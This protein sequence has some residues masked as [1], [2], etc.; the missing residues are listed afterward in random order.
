[1]QHQV[2]PMSLRMAG[3][4]LSAMSRPFPGLT[5]KLFY[6]LYCTPPALKLRAA[7]EQLRQQASMSSLQ[8]SSYP[9]DYT[10]LKVTTYRWGTTGPKILLL[11]GW[12]G[13]PLH[14]K[15]LIASLVAQGYQVISYDAPAHGLSGGKRTNLVQWIHVLEQVI[16]REGELHAIVGHSFGGL[17]AALTLARRNVRVPRLLMLGTALSAPV[18]FD[19]T[20]RLFRIHPVVMPELMLLIRQRLREDL[21]EMDMHR[22]IDHIKA[23]KIWMAYDTTDTL[24]KATEIDDYLQSY[25]AIQSL[26][27]TGDGH[28]R[29]MRHEAVLEGILEVLAAKI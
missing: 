12:G 21:A 7:H 29:I 6:R 28:F 11:H 8:V 2:L 19:E 3:M 4:M 5:A 27:I 14:F 22:Y 15:Q 25:P 13:S 24:A 9:F 26:R 17:S 18:F 16:Q 10:P 23:D 20:L 1:M